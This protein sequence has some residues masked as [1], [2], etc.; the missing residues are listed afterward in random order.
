MTILANGNIN[1]VT[2]QYT[3]HYLHISFSI[4]DVVDWL[5]IVLYPDK[6]KENK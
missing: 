3:E 2:N 6:V 5:T 4:F 1:P